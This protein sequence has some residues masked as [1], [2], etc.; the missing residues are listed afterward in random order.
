MATI[1]QNAH[2]ISAAIDDAYA[3]LT[4]RLADI[5]AEKTAT[6]LSAAVESITMTTDEMF[7]AGGPAR[8]FVFK[9]TIVPA[10]QIDSLTA[11]SNSD[12]K[13]IGG[14]ANLFASRAGKVRSAAF[15]NVTSV[16]SAGCYN[17]FSG[18]TSLVEVKTLPKG[19]IGNGSMSHMFYGCT[20][21]TSIPDKI[22]AT[23]V[24][25]YAFSAMFGNCTALTTAP[26]LPA[27]QTAPEHCS[28]SMFYSCT[29]LTD[30]PALPAT[31]VNSNCYSAMFS[32]CTALATPPAELPATALAGSCYYNMFNE[33]SHLSAIPVMPAFT[34]AIGCCYQMFNNCTAL[35][36]EVVIRLNQTASIATNTFKNMFNGCPN[37][38][39]V[40]LDFTSY[41]SVPSLAN[42]T[43]VQVFGTTTASDSRFEIRVP[44][45]LE[46][47]WKT[48]SN[49]STY[50]THIVG[51]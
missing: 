17:M 2:K 37:L 13:T 26:E 14:C 21:L 11:V 23:Q 22:E 29:S 31:T 16:L 49:W 36:G 48:A 39:K 27:F 1:L 32:R 19:N 18:Q 28:E 20:N 34:P 50:A 12:K 44:A 3:A 33:C 6:N 42:A 7:E 35:T 15:P 41:S 43:A 24:G 51:V 40:T 30:A 47:T 5:P 8:D 4:D 38:T 25:T 45:A 46:A 10:S 9:G